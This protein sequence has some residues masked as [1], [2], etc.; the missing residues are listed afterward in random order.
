[1]IIIIIILSLFNI[2]MIKEFVIS[3][4]LSIWVVFNYDNADSMLTRP[5]LKGELVASLLF[6]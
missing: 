6:P 4:I 5:Q 2:I 3:H 1:M